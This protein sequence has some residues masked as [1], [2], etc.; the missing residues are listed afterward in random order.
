MPQTP[1]IAHCPRS[2]AYFQHSPFAFEQLDTLGFNICLGTDSLASNTDLS[3]FAEMRAFRRV[4][5]RVPAEK[6]LAMVTVNA[7][8]AIQAE[9]FLG[10]IHPGYQADMIA[11]PATLETASAYE[12]IISFTAEVPWMMIAGEPV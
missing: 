10:K 5:A 3:L 9:D 6:I 4:Y 11:I 12:S 7:A 2:H 1:S 8:K